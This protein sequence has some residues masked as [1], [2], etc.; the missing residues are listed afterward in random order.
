MYSTILQVRDP[1]AKEKTQ[2]FQAAI[3]R[4]EQE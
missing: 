4:V 2:T 1:K 3:V